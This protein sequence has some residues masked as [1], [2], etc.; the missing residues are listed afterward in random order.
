M[1]GYARATAGFFAFDPSLLADPGMVARIALQALLLVGSAFFSGSETALFSLSRLDL[2]QLNR[3]RHP[4]AA[5]LHAL[6]NEPRR[7]IISILCGNQ[8]INIA[9]VANMTGMLVILYGEERAGLINV[10]VMVPLLLLLG[11]IT[12]KTIA[13]SNPVR[14]STGLVAVPLSLWVRLITPLRWAI[15]AV[16][17]RITTWIVGQEKAA[18]NIL[19]ID[20]FRSI[21]DEVAHEGELHATERSLIYHLLDAGA[22]EVIEIMTPRPRIAFIDAD[23]GVSEIVA[24]FRRIRHSR[25][26][27]FRGHRDNLVGFLHIERV[28]PLVMD[29]ADLD[30]VKLDDIVSPPMVVPPTKKVNE[31]L[32]FFQSHKARAALVLNEFGGVEGIVTMRDVLTFVFGHLSGEVRGEA[33][34]EERDQDLYEVPGDMRLVDFNNL[35]N[36]GIEDPRMTTIGGVVFRHLDRLPEI[37]DQVTVED[38]QMTVLEMDEQ[39]IARLRVSRGG[40]PEPTEGPGQEAV[41]QKAEEES[42]EPPRERGTNG[43][44]EAS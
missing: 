40:E 27:L 14:V 17:D 36:F 5:A 35:T 10:L 15:R 16:S 20:E 24:R 6:L 38:V 8:L 26:P 41:P 23:L 9:A 30:T 11:E 42:V 34:Y 28:L 32:D 39:R 3:R 19:Q 12:P 18:E 31:M 44:G 13:V 22:T 37:G 4:Q 7:L 25:V 21:V 1:V 33:L 2:Q 43:D 29:R